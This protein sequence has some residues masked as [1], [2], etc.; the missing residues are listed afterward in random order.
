MNASLED[1]LAQSE[2]L[3]R[4]VRAF[5]TRALQDGKTNQPLQSSMAPPQESWSKLACDIAGFQTGRSVGD[6]RQVV[7]MAVPA[8][9]FKF[10]P[11]FRFPPSQATTSF[12]TSGTTASNTGVHFM[13][14]T[15]T[16]EHLSLLWGT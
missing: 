8:D 11:V 13:R 5:A 4:R 14:D 1:R 7:S 15:L 9:C 16:Y 3:H 2:L 10:G 6:L 12:R